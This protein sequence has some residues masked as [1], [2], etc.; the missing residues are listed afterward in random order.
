MNLA[1]TLAQSCRVDLLTLLHQVQEKLAMNGR[2]DP[3]EILQWVGG[4]LD[5]QRE[6]HWLSKWLVGRA[7]GSARIHWL[8]SCGYVVLD[9][10]SKVNTH[11]LAA[12]V[13]CRQIAFAT[14]AIH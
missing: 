9:P 6:Q 3:V 14:A 1:S 12:K 2:L 11:M 7:F 13:F 4:D 10:S 5:A 8:V